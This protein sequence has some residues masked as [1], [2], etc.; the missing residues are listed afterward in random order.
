[1]RKWGY[2]VA[3]TVPALL[4][5]GHLAGGWTFLLV[6]LFVFGLVPLADLFVGARSDN[7]TETHYRAIRDQRY[8]RVITH[9]YVP[10]Q[11]ALVLWGAL[12]FGSGALTALEAVGLLFATG[13]VTGGIGIT[14]AHELGHRANRFEQRLA[15]ALLWTVCYMHFFIE[16]N[17]GHHARVATPN[18]PASARMGESFYAF[19]PR[20]LIGGFRHAWSLERTRLQR[21]NHTLWSVHNRLLWYIALPLFL[22]GTL[23]WTCGWPAVTFFFGQ[24]LVAVGLLELVNYVEHYGLSRRELAP[25]RFEKVTPRHS[26]DAGE[27]I[28][29][30]LLFDLQ[31]HADH[32]A[33]ANR[34][35]QTLRQLGDQQRL[36]TGYAGMITLALIPPLWRHIMD[37]RARAVQST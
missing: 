29:N 27:V 37:P 16:H 18:D 23:G 4:V 36:P 21:Q 25:G 34:R 3:Y 11:W 19:F 6:P 10:L 33:N 26:W 7:Q 8:Y 20:S 12:R 17:L 14:L 5:A 31:K 30:F 1:M 9:L 13:V 2:L 28:T 24:S 35:Y 15:Q 32:H 22:A